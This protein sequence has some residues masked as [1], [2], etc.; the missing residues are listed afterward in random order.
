MES[1]YPQKRPLRGRD[2]FA[3]KVAG[4]FLPTGLELLNAEDYLHWVSSTSPTSCA[5]MPLHLGCWLDAKVDDS[6]H[7]SRCHIA[8]PDTSI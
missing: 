7:R 1:S 2:A 8:S 4:I 3:A 5:G 6:K